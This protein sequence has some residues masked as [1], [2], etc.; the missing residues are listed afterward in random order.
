MD[1]LELGRRIKENEQLQDT[2]LIMLSSVNKISAQ[3]YQEAGF[4]T[5][6]TKPA[7]Q[8]ELYDSIVNALNNVVR[9]EV[10]VSRIQEVAR[11]NA[12]LTVK[13]LL[14]EDNE[15]NQEVAR[16]ILSMSG[17]KCD[18]VNS[19]L[20]AVNAIKDKDYD[21]VFM[22]CMMPDMDGYEATKLIRS[23]ET[24]T[25]TRLPIIALTANAMRGDREHCLAAGMD[26]YLSKPV[27]PAR[28]V[29]MVD[30]W[31][32]RADEPDDGEAADASL[33]INADP[34]AWFDR[35]ALIARCMGNEGLA[36][37][38]IE[39]FIA[40]SSTDIID[41]EGAIAAGDTTR[42]MHTAHRMKG[43]AANLSMEK[44]RATAAKL[45]ATARD[46]DLIESKNW[47]K[48]LKL[49]FEQTRLLLE[50]T[51]AD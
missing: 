45:E 10:P 17:F 38:L 51:A 33:E 11:R 3:Y 13:I 37:K 6:L 4:T 9:P 26:D 22:D 29:T 48:Q 15:I 32:L 35:E 36:D 49:S 24:S 40:Q 8:S 44:V 39:K 21:L 19:G 2:T 27:D 46:E 34:K 5:Y 50:K 12:Q 23:F 43:A 41:A 1:G 31:H 18:I 47:Y 30:K 7:K 14:A 28:M 25:G 20:E 16:E 42:L